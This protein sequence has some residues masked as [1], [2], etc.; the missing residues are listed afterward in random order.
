M[1]SIVQANRKEN[2]FPLSH[3]DQPFIFLAGPIQNAPKWHNDAIN[4]LIEAH[5]D[6]CIATPSEKALE[7]EA[8]KYLARHSEN[9]ELPNKR[10][11]EW[12]Y[13]EIASRSG[14]IL[15]WLANPER[16][17]RN[18]AY[19]ATTRLELGQW[20]TEYKRDNKLRVCVGIEK[21]FPDDK[22]IRYDLKEY[23]H[24]HVHESL[25]DVC[26]CALQKAYPKINV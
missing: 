2:R 6:V 22:S 15:F 9:I 1:P 7:R 18:K 14:A 17:T 23:A 19:G 26:K 3:N 16:L 20:M 4:I 10:A 21:G 13:L 5:P 11:W 24:I 8:K 25:E 12:R